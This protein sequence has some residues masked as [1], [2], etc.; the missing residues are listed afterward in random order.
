MSEAGQHRPAGWCGGES[1]DRGPK[2]NHTTFPELKRYLVWQERCEA[3][4]DSIDASVSE[5]EKDKIRS[6]LPAVKQLAKNFRSSSAPLRSWDQDKMKER[7]AKLGGGVAVIKA[8]SCICQR[9]S[10]SRDSKV[11]GSSEVEVNE[12]KAAHGPAFICALGPVSFAATCTGPP[13]RCPEC[14]EGCPRGRHCARW[15][16]RRI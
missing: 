15:R 6:N 11:G 14:H 13:E 1:E 5:Y 4:R 12:T 7:L 9:S 8:S 10:K 16:H 2:P 3:I